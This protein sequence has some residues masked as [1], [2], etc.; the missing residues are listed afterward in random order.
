[1]PG[2]GVAAKFDGVLMFKMRGILFAAL[3]MSPAAAW[4]DDVE[5]AFDE[6]QSISSE[7]EG[8]MATFES[9]STSD[10]EACAITDR[11]LI[12]AFERGVF[13]AQRAVAAIDA[14]ASIYNS[15]RDGPASEMLADANDRRLA[16]ENLK[17]KFQDAYDRGC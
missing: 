2:N 17:Q 6:L 11:D 13:A 12:P 8:Y 3:L 1:L 7:T 16:Y 4:A 5:S 14:K 15:F 9:S 10:A